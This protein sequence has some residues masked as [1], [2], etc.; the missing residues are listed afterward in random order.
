[1]EV[2]KISSKG[3]IT[4]PISV[5]NR[6]HLKAGDKIVILEENGRFYFENSAMLA[7]KRV[8]DAFAQEA[9]KAGFSTEEEMQ[10]YMKEIRREVR[11]Y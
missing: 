8:E 1:M 7:F 6:L 3:Q 2:A 4:I 5:R 9:E 10:D 11:G